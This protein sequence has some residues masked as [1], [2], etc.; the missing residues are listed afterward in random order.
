MYSA[1]QGQELIYHVMPPY[2]IL[3]FKHIQKTI[4]PTIALE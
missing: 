4:L 1:K 2:A 3:I